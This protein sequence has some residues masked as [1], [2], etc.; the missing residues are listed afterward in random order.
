[1]VKKLLSTLKNRKLIDIAQ[2]QKPNEWRTQ[3]TKNIDQE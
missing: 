3:F 2:A 1:M